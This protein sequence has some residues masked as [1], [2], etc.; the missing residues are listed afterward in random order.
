MTVW[1]YLERK[2]KGRKDRNL[3]TQYECLYNQYVG[4]EETRTR[5]RVTTIQYVS[6]F[7][8]RVKLF[9]KFSTGYFPKDYTHT[10]TYSRTRDRKETKYLFSRGYSNYTR[11]LLFSKSKNRIAMVLSQVSFFIAAMYAWRTN[12][13]ETDLT[14][15][16]Y[17]VNTHG[18]NDEN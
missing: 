3:I 12:L 14:S 1:K 10:H 9:V 15:S 7:V 5:T 6:L 17:F 11:V 8:I 4:T 2:K 13:V 16:K 18:Y